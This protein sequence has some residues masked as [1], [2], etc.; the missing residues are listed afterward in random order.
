MAHH[1]YPRIGPHP[2]ST[3]AQDSCAMRARVVTSIVNR[4]FFFMCSCWGG[5][6]LRRRKQLRFPQGNPNTRHAHTHAHA[7]THAR[8]PGV[9]WQPAAAAGHIHWLCFACTCYFGRSKAAQPKLVPSS[10]LRFHTSGSDSNPNLQPDCTLQPS[11]RLLL[12]STSPTRPPHCTLL[13]VFC[14]C[15]QVQAMRSGPMR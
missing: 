15:S 5:W 1:I 13:S 10:L 3:S 8:L 4:I 7:C 6:Q 11:T 9:R 2:T 14:P 12:P